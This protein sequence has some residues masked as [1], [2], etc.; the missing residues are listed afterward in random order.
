MTWRCSKSTQLPTW[1]RFRLGTDDELVETMPLAAFGYPFGRMLAADN[2]YPTVSV[3]TGTITALRRKGGKLSAIQLDASVNPGNSGGPVVDK[4]G[5]LIGIVVS[6]MVMAGSTSRSPSAAC[7]SSS[8]APRWCSA[9]R[10]LTFPER[11]KPRQFEIDAYAFDRRLLDDIVV[12][13]ALTDPADDTRTL[14]AKRQRQSLRGRRLGLFPRRALLFKPILVVHKG[15]AGSRANSRRMSFRSAAGSFRGWPSIRSSK[16]ATNGSCHCL[17]GERFAGKP[18]GL[19]SVS[20]GAGRTTQ[21]ATA[22]RIEMRLENAP[23]TE[24]AYELQ[25]HRGPKVFTPIQRPAP[26]Q[27]HADGG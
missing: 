7:G 3:N 10:G 21:L 25:A 16:T 11:S 17:N 4:K 22:D 23:P 24:V 1:W 26:D 19:P 20:F 15:R 12:E 8:P 13:L 9:I 18:V 6:G 27:K 2:R 14:P 5:N